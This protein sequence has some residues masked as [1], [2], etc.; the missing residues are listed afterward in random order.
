MEKKSHS[1]KIRTGERPAPPARTRKKRPKAV[2]AGKKPR[3]TGRR[4]LYWLTV[5]FVWCGILGV[6]GF[7]WVAHDLPDISNLPAPGRE[8][9]AVVKAVNGATLANYG[10]VR[11]QWLVYEEIPEVM[12]LSLLAVED[13]RF[14]QHG[15]VDPVG[16]GRALVANLRAGG[17]S[18]GGSTLTQQLAKNIFLSSERSLKRKVQEMLLAFWLERSYSKEQILTLYLNRVYF[19]AGTYGIDAASETYFGHT[20]RRLSLPE[21]AMLAGLVKAPSRLAPSHNY[22]GAK[23]RSDQVLDRMVDAGFITVEAMVR[24]KNS[25]PAMARDAAGP[26]VRYFTDWVLSEVDRL[27]GARHGPVTILTTLDPTAQRAAEAVLKQKLDEAGK[28]RNVGQGALVS[29]APDG[30]VMAMMGGKSYG[31]SQFNRVTQ[32]RRQPGSAFKPLV[33]LAGI[34]AGLSPQAIFVDGPVTV[35]GWTPQNF[36]EDY[37]GPVS[38]SQAFAR[39]LNTVAVRVSQHAGPRSVAALG[40]RFGIESSLLP[41]P[42]IAL[43]A[44]EMTLMELTK[45]FAVFAN[46]GERVTPYAIVEIQD[47]HGQIL[48]RYQ[49]QTRQRVARPDHVAAVVALMEESMQT[50]TGRAALIDRPAAGKTGTSQDYRDALFVGFTSDLVTGIWVGNDDDSPTRHVTGGTLPAQIWR[51][52]MI[53]AHVGRPVRPLPSLRGLAERRLMKVQD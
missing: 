48:Y 34:E 44:S 20:A 12:I 46:G 17:V 39:S 2:P 49:P 5:L 13:R 18:Q 16:I 11:G 22:K 4:V 32:A 10:P 14:F 45:V 27:L 25:A 33:Y 36:A 37:A 7:G 28:A 15:G 42:S 52:F 21:A 43:G 50:G 6:I 9:S 19:G 3:R 26:D 41:V 30:A 31:E 51:D 35:D 23:A 40:K 47:R 29:L 53:D 24:A 8:T 1:N 38:L